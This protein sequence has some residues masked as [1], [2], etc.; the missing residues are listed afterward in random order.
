MSCITKRFWSFT[1]KQR[2]SVL[3]NKWSRRG[4][5]L[6]WKKNDWKTLKMLVQADPSLKRPRYLNLLW[7]VAIYSLYK[8]QILILA[9][10]L[11]AL[12]CT[13]SEAS[14]GD[15]PALRVSVI[16]F[17]INLGFEGF[18]SVGLRQTSRVFQLF[19]YI[20]KQVPICFS[21]W[22]ERC[23]VVSVWSSKN[24]SWTTKHPPTFH[25]HWGVD[26]IS[27]LGSLVL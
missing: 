15:R 2:W 20:L 18:G 17:Q 10:K 14:A 25:W 26:Y 16:S 1:A 8:A 5:V 19:C 23:N 6:R 3:L 21:C 7:K 12:A 11:K 4:L 27:F 13:K 22:G 24:V 9:T